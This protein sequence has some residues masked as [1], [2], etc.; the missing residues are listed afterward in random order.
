MGKGLAT[1]KKRT[2]LKLEKK[3]PNKNVTTELGTLVVD[4]L[5]N[6]FLRLPLPSGRGGDSSWMGN[7]GDLFLKKNHICINTVLSKKY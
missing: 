7:P 3:N 6:F 5:K 1:S 4:P 2:F